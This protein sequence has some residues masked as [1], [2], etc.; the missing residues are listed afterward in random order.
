MFIRTFFVLVIA[1]APCAAAE[2]RIPSFA[3]ASNMPI[4]EFDNLK[5]ALSASGITILGGPA[6]PASEPS[7]GT[8]SLSSSMSSQEITRAFSDSKVSPLQ[9]A[10]ERFEHF[11]PRIGG[12]TPAAIQDFPWQVVLVDGTAPLDIRIPFCGG[13]IIASNWVITAAHCVTGVDKAADIDIISGSAYPKFVNQGDRV[14][15][16]RIVSNEN[17]VANTWENDIALLK[18][19][20]PVKL[21]SPIRL[22]ANNLQVPVNAKATVSGWGAVTAYGPMVDKLL[23]AD[24]PIVANST[25]N[26]KESY[27]GGVKPGMICAG[28]R[29]GGLDACQ[30]DSGGPLMIKVNGIPTLVGIVSW[31]LGCA[32]RLK[33]GVYTRMTAYVDWVDKS[34]SGVV[35]QR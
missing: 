23:K 27:D 1:W 26:E 4:N 13:S 16:A 21:G 20:R 31:G 29:A 5:A 6:I 25:C 17:Y 34:M 7:P 19:V 12:G 33:Y 3:P 35:A 11:D 30:G 18:L 32:Q 2:P 24:V 8:P 15:V 14:K 22:P 9:A 10:R 28:Y